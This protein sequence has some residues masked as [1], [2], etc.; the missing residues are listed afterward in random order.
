MAAT[1]GSL[2]SL[3]G[4]ANVSGDGPAGFRRPAVACRI[5]RSTGHAVA[6]RGAGLPPIE[7][8]AS[9]T[10]VLASDIAAFGETCGDGAEYSIPVVIGSWRIAPQVLPRPQRAGPAGRAWLDTRHRAPV[11]NLVRPR[12]GSGG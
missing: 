12:S 11:G 1:S 5:R 6:A 2:T 10:A 9:Y 7:A 8:M 4:K 3:P